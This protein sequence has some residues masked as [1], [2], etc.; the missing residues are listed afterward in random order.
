MHATRTLISFMWFWYRHFFHFFFRVT[1]Q[2]LVPILIFLI[3]VYEYAKF[4]SNV[5]FIMVHMLNEDKKIQRTVGS[6][7]NEQTRSL[8]GHTI[9]NVTHKI[10]T[11]FFVLLF[12]VV[13]SLSVL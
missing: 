9:H 13:V 1:S 10:S 2:A 11:R 6:R 4:A 7:E 12:F 5:V 8:T 3:K